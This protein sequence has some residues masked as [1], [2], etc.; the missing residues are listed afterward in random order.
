MN[1]EY[2]EKLKAIM[3]KHNTEVWNNACEHDPAYAD[4]QKQQFGELLYGEPKR[5]RQNK[6]KKPFQLGSCRSK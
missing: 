6:P 1:T 4:A 5:V 2:N 3:K